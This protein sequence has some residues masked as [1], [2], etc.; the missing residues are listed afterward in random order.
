MSSGIPTFSDKALENLDKLSIT[1]ITD[2]PLPALSQTAVKI[3]DAL[4]YIE[5]VKA[6]FMEDEPEV[7]DEFLLLMNDFRNHG[8]NTTGVINRIRQLFHEHPD[9]VTSFDKFLTPRYSAGATPVSEEDEVEDEESEG[10]GTASPGAAGSRAATPTQQ[11]L[12]RIGSLSAKVD[13]EPTIAYIQ[14]VK[15]QCDAET[16]DQFMAILA[17]QYDDPESFDE[18]E[19]IRDV[20]ELFE[21]HPELIPGTRPKIVITRYL[22]PEAAALISPVDSYEVVLWPEDRSCGREWILENVPGA[23]ALVVTVVDKVFPHEILRSL[24]TY[25]TPGDNLRVV[26]TMSVGYEHLDVQA[27]ASRGIKIG[28]TPEVLTDAVADIA[29]MLAL[30]ASRNVRETMQIVDQGRW[31]NFNWAP[32]LFCGPQIGSSPVSPQRTVG[33]IG[34]G[35]ISQATLARLI[36]FGITD[37][38]YTGN[39]QNK[40]D[41]DRDESLRQKLGLRSL[42]R[43]NLDELA[44]ESDAVFVLAPGGPS[45]YHVVNETFLKKMKKTSI[46]VNAARG[47]LVDSDAL[48]QAL[49]EKWIWGAGVDVVEGEPNVTQDHPLVKEPRCA[50]IPHIGSA[51]TETRVGMATLAIENAIAVLTDNPMPKEL[52]L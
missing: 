13:G 45:T 16:W 21:D 14:R 50:V 41:M 5:A 2:N 19:M 17:R 3:R 25:G 29:V 39:P 8:I 43:V 33:F 22:G 30:M 44:I 18:E 49:R 27:I 48:A 38:L 52:L 1:D 40:P 11:D 24:Q 28:Y 7:Y 12:H 35:R 20:E 9:L 51:T 32:F 46:L 47:S 26:S 15:R 4:D 42:R 23:S 37:C 31:P 10:S 36:P 6:R 34:F